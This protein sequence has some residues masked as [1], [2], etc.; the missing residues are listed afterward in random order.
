MSN[1]KT[2]ILKGELA[3]FCGMEILRLSVRSLA[4]AL[5]AIRTNFP[6]F[7]KFL[8][9]RDFVI[10]VDDKNINENMLS[11]LINKSAT[12]EP[13]ISGAK[14]KAL[15]VV[16]IIAGTLLR[17]FIAPH[18]AFA[19]IGGTT[20]ATTAFVVANSTILTNISLALIFGGIAGLL[21]TPP[22]L[23]KG[24]DNTEWGGG[25]NT[26]RAGD[27]VPIAYGEIITGTKTA[28]LSLI[29]DSTARATANGLAGAI[30]A[31][32]LEQ[33]DIPPINEDEGDPA[34]AGDPLPGNPK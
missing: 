32:A 1:C 4:E 33:G 26:F 20:S 9:N 12:L 15:S 17:A 24:N 29:I 16:A 14:S 23:D 13:V 8:A 2:I 28:S 18:L 25:L 21:F 30:I 11:A 19:G 3:E 7:D 31:L 5:N 10:Y 27:A 34:D 6:G 22:E